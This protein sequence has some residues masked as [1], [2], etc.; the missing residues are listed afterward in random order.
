MKCVRLF[1]ILWDTDGDTADE[2]G[3]PSEHIAIVDDDW[4]P[5]DD[6]ADC[7]ANQYGFCVNGCAFTVLTN[8]KLSEAG[9][10]L[11][12]GGIIEYPDSEGTIRRRDQYG[13]CE[14]VREPTDDLFGN[15]SHCS[16][17]EWT[18]KSLRQAIRDNRRFHKYE[19]LLRQIRLRIF[20]YEDAGR[21]DKAQQIIDRI[22]AICG[23][24]WEKRAKRLEN[25]M[26]ERLTQWPLDN[27]R[28]RTGPMEPIYARDKE[29]GRDRKR[30]C[31]RWR[32][33]RN[34]FECPIGSPR[35]VVRTIT[36]GRKQ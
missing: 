4:T 26:L 24:T 10:E 17:E 3:L 36:T 31:R 13:N 5:V 8:P 7:F 34:T 15:G 18:M 2:L 11:D 1:N 33:I 29:P 16:S 21:L 27:S 23:P 25:K 9:Y 22:K 19:R 32:T 14:E 12:D 35:L 28:R 6:A 20:D 30:H